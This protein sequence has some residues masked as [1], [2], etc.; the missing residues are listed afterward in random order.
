MARAGG[1]AEKEPF[2]VDTKKLKSA[3]S[4]GYKCQREGRDIIV[5]IQHSGRVVSM[6]LR[7]AD[8]LSRLP[9]G[10]LYYEPLYHYYWESRDKKYQAV[11]ALKQVPDG[12]RYDK[13]PSVFIIA[14]SGNNPQAEIISEDVEIPF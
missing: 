12:L 10:E 3:V 8:F 5:C 6:T 7:N 4:L 11:F 13:Y 9:E 14:S 2:P 1:N